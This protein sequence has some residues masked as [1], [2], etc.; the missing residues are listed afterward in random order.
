MKI[1][2][3]G[4]DTAARTIDDVIADARRAEAEGFS[5]YGL[6]QIFALDAMTVLAIV[7]VMASAAVTRLERYLLR[8]KA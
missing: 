6:P 1:G 5:S 3:F 2:I 7:V 8:W 4:G